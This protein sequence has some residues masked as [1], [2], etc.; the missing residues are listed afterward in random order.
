[1]E[2][3]AAHRDMVPGPKSPSGLANRYS[4]IPYTFPAALPLTGLGAISDAL[5][6]RVKWTNPAVLIELN[7]LI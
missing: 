7:N 6:G 1:S 5:V 4:T 3:A 2:L